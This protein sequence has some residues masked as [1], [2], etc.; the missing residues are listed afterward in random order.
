MAIRRAEELLCHDLAGDCID[1][2][3]GELTRLRVVSDNGA[4]FKSDAFWRFRRPAPHEHIRTRHYAPE[5]NGVVERF[6]RS[7]KYEHL[8]QREIEQAPTLAEEVAEFLDVQR[9]QTT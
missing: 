1:L 2:E 3:S 8:Y 5:T 9:G 6:H 4:A 7:L